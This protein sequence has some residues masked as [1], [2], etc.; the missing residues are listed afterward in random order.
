M[1]GSYLHALTV[2]VEGRKA[3]AGPI[4]KGAGP[5]G[6]KGRGFRPHLSIILISKS[7]W[8]EGLIIFRVG[9]Q[10]FYMVFYVKD[11]IFI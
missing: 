10:V 8:S 11:K 5:N 3:E 2:G 7:D 1:F 4:D 9:P 6:P